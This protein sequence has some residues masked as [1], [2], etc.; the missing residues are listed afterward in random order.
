[1][2]IRGQAS[3]TAGRWRIWRGKLQA[4]SRSPN[5]GVN[6]ARGL[7]LGDGSPAVLP[8][9]AAGG[10]LGGQPFFLCL[11]AEKAAVLEFAQNTRM[12]Y[13]SP[14]SVYQALRVLTVAVGYVC[15]TILQILP[16]GLTSTIG[17][18]L[19]HEG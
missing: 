6:D 2:V 18:N 4:A 16:A 1:M 9:A 11:G 7:T 5:P 3:I 12:L 10:P 17:A 19:T 15:H 8:A 14:E 13:R